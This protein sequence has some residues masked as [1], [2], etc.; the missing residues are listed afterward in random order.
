[1]CDVLASLGVQKVPVALRFDP[2]G[3][4][5]EVQACQGDSRPE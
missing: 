2:D 3:Q 4:A 1:M 5:R